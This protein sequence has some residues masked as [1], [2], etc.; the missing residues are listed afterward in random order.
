MADK[1]T[2]FIRLAAP[3]AQRGQREFGVPASVTIAQG[4]L[5]SAWG[6]S[7]IGRA[8]NYFGIKAS[9]S[10]PLAIGSVVVPTQEF[11]GG[12]LGTVN[13]RFRAYRSAADSFR[14]H[15]LFLRSN[16]R[17][18]PAFRVAHDANAFARALQAAG[19]ATDPEYANK[20]IATMRANNLYR[21]DASGPVEPVKPVKPVVP[22]AAVKPAVAAVQRD[23]NTHLR[24]LGS[25]ELLAV[26]GVWD[27]Y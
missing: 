14:D 19:Y 23:L 12:R 25:P 18:Q 26:D 21:F 24:K 9:G 8:N 3:G 6:T 22:P 13:G 20:L 2:S 7:H 10:S 11:V 27:A 16:S 17:Y 1:I 5:E 4:A 15:G